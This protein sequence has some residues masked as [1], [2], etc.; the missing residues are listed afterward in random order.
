MVQLVRSKGG[1]WSFQPACTALIEWSTRLSLRHLW[2]GRSWVDR[3]SSGRRLKT[4]LL[5]LGCTARISYGGAPDKLV[6]K[7]WLKWPQIWVAQVWQMARGWFGTRQLSRRWPAV[8]L[9]WVWGRLTRP[10]WRCG[11]RP[12]VVSYGW[13]GPAMA[14][15]S[16]G[17]GGLWL[18]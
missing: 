15:G 9:F 14:T 13:R 6:A 4:A 18:D 11:D 16:V 1:N 5:W 2:T 10:E 3:S 12:F 17:D 7:F 8:K